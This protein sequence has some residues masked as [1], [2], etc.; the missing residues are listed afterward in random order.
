M[1]TRKDGGLKNA[2]RAQQSQV[3]CSMHYDTHFY[4]GYKGRQKNDIDSF[5]FSFFLKKKKEKKK[6]KQQQQPRKNS[7]ETTNYSSMFI[8]S[9]VSSARFRASR[10]AIFSLFLIN[11]SSSFL[12]AARRRA[13]SLAYKAIYQT[14]IISTNFLVI[15]YYPFCFTHLHNVLVLL[16]GLLALFD[17]AGFAGTSPGKA[18]C[19]E[20]SFMNDLCKPPTLVSYLVIQFISLKDKTYLG[21]MF[22]YNQVKPS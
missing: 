20:N 19:Q 11:S 5:F 14:I 6:K 7:K 9:L 16:L 10:A 15:W 1:A 3:T 17:A 12:M 18:A 13:I 2:V 22:H 21:G 8:F 4:A